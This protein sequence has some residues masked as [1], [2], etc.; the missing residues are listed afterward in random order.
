MRSG[1]AQH[2]SN[3]REDLA[4]LI[5]QFARNVTQRGFLGGDQ[6]LRQFAAA[7]GNLGQAREQP[8]V[9]ANQGKTIQQDRQQ[10]RGQKDI[11]LLLHAIVNLNDA[12]SG[13]LFIL[14]VL[15]QQSSHG[16]AQRGL[17]LLERQLDLLARLFFLALLREGENRGRRH[18]RTG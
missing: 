17:P 10:S 1:A 12:L 8:P 9:P 2:G 15:H 13:L 18:P 3:R 16:R 4:E 7:L 14:A 11:D 6:L 5:V